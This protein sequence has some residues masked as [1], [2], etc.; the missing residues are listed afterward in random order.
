LKKYCYLYRSS[1]NLDRHFF[2]DPECLQDIKIL[3]EDGKFK[4]KLNYIVDRILNLNTS[5]YDDYIKLITFNSLT[6]IRLFPNGMNARIYCKE[7]YNDEGILVIIAAMF[8]EK[9]KDNKISKE[10]QNR[11]R[12]I[13]KYNYEIIN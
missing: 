4:K 1:K 12:I 10:L 9:K 5:Y 11:L 2:I 8:L 3:L 7:G 13:E 6:E